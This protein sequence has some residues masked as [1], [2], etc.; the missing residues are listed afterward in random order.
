M[1]LPT[2]DSANVRHLRRQYVINPRFQ[3][4]YVGI[5]SAVVFGA[6]LLMGVGVYLIQFR[7]SQSRILSPAWTHAQENTLLI[8]LTSLAFAV[9]M[10]VVFGFWSIFVTH[11]ICG[12]LYVIG[13][14]LDAL[15]AG[16][17][18]GRRSLRKKDEFGAVYDHLWQLVDS[19]K[20]RKQIELDALQEVT[21]NVR[22]LRKGDEAARSV[23]VHAVVSRLE[24]ICNEHAKS[25]GIESDALSTPSG[26]ARSDTDVL[27]HA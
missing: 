15:I 6:S 21:S 3:W 10:A 9:V 23:D 1:S 26:K 20:A 22:N 13:Q 8:A 27:E 12:P 2:G 25:L 7:E 14:C 24:V 5:G 17:F 11:R 18:P 16:R 4:K 19:L